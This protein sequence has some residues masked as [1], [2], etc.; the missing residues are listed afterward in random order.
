MALV[1]VTGAARLYPVNLQMCA[2]TLVRIVLLPTS[3][4]CA[5]AASSMGL[6]VQRH[7]VKGS[8]KAAKESKA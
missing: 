4:H 2:L 1:I 8:L 5:S 3:D 7:S 6:L